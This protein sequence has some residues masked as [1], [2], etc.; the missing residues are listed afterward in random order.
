MATLKFNF[1]MNSIQQ[2]YIGKLDGCTCG[3]AGH[4]IHTQEFSDKRFAKDGIRLYAD[5]KKV[6]QIIDEMAEQDLSISSWK[7]E[8]QFRTKGAEGYILFI[9]TDD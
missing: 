3:C 8:I 7:D 9:K 2:I 4:Y 1:E 5:D 6:K